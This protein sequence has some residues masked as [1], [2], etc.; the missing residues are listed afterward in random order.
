MLTDALTTDVEHLDEQ[1]LQE[2]YAPAS[3][4]LEQF[5]VAEPQQEQALEHLSSDGLESP[6]R[7]EY[8]GELAERP[9]DAERE[10]YEQLVARLYETQF[11]EAVYELAAEAAAERLERFGESEAATASET[12]AFFES[13]LAPLASETE[14]SFERLAEQYASHDLAPLSEDELDRL[15]ESLEPSTGHLTPA[16]EDFFKAVWSKAKALGKAAVG[17]A[18]AGLKAVGKV[19]PLGWVF[20]RLKR[21]VRPLLRRV[22]QLAIGRLPMALRPAATTVARRL[23]G[24]SEDEGPASWLEDGRVGAETWSEAWSEAYERPAEEAGWQEQ[25]EQLAT[26][27]PDLVQREFDAR[28]A[29]LLYVA[30]EAEQ[31]A[32]AAEAEQDAAREAE[33]RE[34]LLETARET[35]VAEVD[36]LETGSDPTRQLEQF[37][38]AVMAALKV[39]VTVVGRQR[40]VGFLAGH[41]ATLIKPYVGAQ[42]AR[43][44]ADA[45]VSTGMSMVGL[46]APQER[47]ALAG[48]AIAGTVEGTVRRLAEQGP[49]VFEDARV[50]EAA[51]QEAFSA[52]AAESFP[53]AVVLPQLHETSARSSAKGTW[54]MRPA[55]GRRRYR[56]YT[57]VLSVTVTPQLATAVHGFGRVPLREVLRSRWGINAPVKMR[58]YLYEAVLGTSLAGI[59]RH[60][61][62]VPGLGTSAQRPWQLFLPLTRRTAG[63]LFGEP[64]LGRDVDEQFT[65]TPRRLALG[66]RFVV[67]VP[68]TS[69]PP[70]PAPRRPARPSQVDLT[71][72][73]PRGTATVFI[74]LSDRDTS[75][76][77]ASLRRGESAT[78]VLLLLRGIYDATLRSMLSGSPGRHVK[79]VHEAAAH[80]QFVGAALGAVARALL[81]KFA[82]K[83]L[84]FVAKALAEYFARRRQE[85]LTAADSP[86]AGVTIVVTVRWPGMLTAL[87]KGLKGDGSGAAAAM[88]RALLTAPDVSV[89][90]VPGVRR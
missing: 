41:L 57:Q 85:F 79:V 74:H 26:A 10:G 29:G 67:L 2:L 80:E 88:A 72:D 49:Q 30:D 22:L 73:I 47:E 71:L 38:P 83:V 35:F 15:F 6:F 81:K 77:V 64:G 65:A 32:L 86:A 59:A 1:P 5:T 75:G 28:L 46:E 52:A 69:R 7:S 82:D 14:A 56:A 42:V 90:T 31:E 54:V 87:G 62:R 63:L 78:P 70:A 33:D 17:A 20:D 4:F 11:S 45:I 24:E 68:E 58:A 48:E 66:Q 27:D 3:P 37:L 44:L 53:P 51:L 25:G 18:K 50:L 8:A 39:G 12:R 13:Y 9:H 89:K 60:E 34:A 61:G 21:L 36:R 43:Q 23:F 19:V 40:V 76:I 16:F 84:A 55:R